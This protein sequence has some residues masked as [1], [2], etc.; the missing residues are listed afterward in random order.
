[1]RTN[2]FS[3]EEL[4]WDAWPDFASGKFLAEPGNF[5]YINPKDGTVL[6]LV[7]GG[8]FL[9]GD[10]KFAVTL[11]EYYLAL[12]PV[13][14]AQYKHFVDETGHRPPHLTMFEQPVW[15]GK[16]FQEE[17]SEHP[18]VSVS[19]SDAQAYCGWSGLRLPTEL[20]WE[21]GSRG[22][23]GREYPW[24]AQWDKEKC[25][26]SKTKNSDTTG[27][28]WEYPEGCSP[29]GH[30]QMVGNVWERCAD[31]HS[32]IAYNR[33]RGGDLTPPSSG[34]DHVVRGGSWASGGEDVFLCA[35]R[36]TQ[37]IPAWRRF[38]GFRCARTP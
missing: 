22:V 19:W 32:S 5:L 14:N 29:F 38:I 25:R 13:T 37:D 3:Q 20:E 24:G 30:Y 23:D 12:H 16:D 31:W 21:K 7:P 4:F 28:V 2:E 35:H 8:E 36:D 27:G 15:Q 1:M 11:P 33:Y 6:G 34:G 26:N 17:K 9:A 18:V 10:D